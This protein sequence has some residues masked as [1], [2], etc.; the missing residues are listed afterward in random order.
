MVVPTFPGGDFHT[1]ALSVVLHCIVAQVKDHLAED[2]PHTKNSSLAALHRD[3]DM[4]LFC[5]ALQAVC[6]QLCQLMK[7]GLLSE[8]LSGVLIQS[9]N[10]DN[11][12]YQCNQPLRNR[13][14]H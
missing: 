1:A 14:P 8:E 10:L 3:G 7:V 4:P 12:L 13:K 5:G 11:I 9:R 2:L 6:R